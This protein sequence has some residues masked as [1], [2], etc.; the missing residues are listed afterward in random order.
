MHKTKIQMAGIKSVEDA[1]ICADCGVDMIGLLVGQKHKSDQFIL[2][3]TARE[4][5]NAL[6]K[7]VKTTLITH[8]ENAEEIIEIAKYIGVDFVQFH[9]GI[10]DL[11]VQKVKEKLPNIKIIRVVHIS[12]S[13]KILSNLENIKTVD[14]YFTD[15]LNRRANKIGG[16]GLVH[17]LE[18]DKMLIETLE[19]PVFIAGGL[20][21]EN[22]QEA[23]KFCKPFGVDVNSGC[24]AKDGGRDKKKVEEF[25]RKVREI[26]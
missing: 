8:L 17:N 1:L 3:S 25:V 15:S 5:K 7:S 24:R 13:G 4:I 26:E 16:T 9:S 6:P 12:K 21:P 2:K 22:V 19:K 20:T 14:F 11:E 23:I 10:K 18:T